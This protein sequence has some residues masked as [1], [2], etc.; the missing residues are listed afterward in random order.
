VRL[1]PRIAIFSSTS[2][3]AAVRP[4]VQKILFPQPAKVRFSVGAIALIGAFVM[5]Y[6]LGAEM[7]NF[8]ALI[9]FMG[10]NAAAFMRY[11][12]RDQ[13]RDTVVRL[14][15]RPRLRDLLFALA[16]PKY[17]RQDRRYHLDGSGNRLRRLDDAWLPQ[18][19]GQL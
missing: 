12:V 3:A 17:S 15:T 5:S 18:R 8:G 9:A 19:P 2:L 13:K 16:G 10:V 11:A 6:G 1:R 7:L 4:Q 14:A